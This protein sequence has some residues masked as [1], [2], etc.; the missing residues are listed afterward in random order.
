MM[1]VNDAFQASVAVGWLRQTATALDADTVT[2]LV[3]LSMSLAVI[4]VWA[5]R[6]ICSL[7]HIHPQPHWSVQNQFTTLAPSFSIFT[8]NQYT[9]HCY[10]RRTVSLSS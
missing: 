3:D 10:I 5:P 1:E 8:T 9:S 4:E 2:W 6:S 7:I